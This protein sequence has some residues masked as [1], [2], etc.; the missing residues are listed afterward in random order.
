M[1]DVITIDDIPIQVSEWDAALV[2]QAVL[3]FGRGGKTFSCNTFRDLLPEMAHGHIGKAIRGLA[4][5]KVI[6]KVR[7]PSGEL[8]RVRSTSD[9]THG[10]DLFVY[11]LTPKGEELAREQYE[12]GMRSEVAA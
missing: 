7:K 12:R 10:K 2:K 11:R 9:A 1:A 4:Q 8:A 6:D 5:S 3:A